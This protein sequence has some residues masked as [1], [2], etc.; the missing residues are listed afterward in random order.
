MSFYKNA[1]ALAGSITR[2]PI[3]RQCNRL[4]DAAGMDR[5]S[6]KCA[7]YTRYAPEVVN[8]S[9]RG[10]EAPA[11]RMH[12]DGGNDNVAFQ[13]WRLGFTG[14]EAPVSRIYLALAG[15]ARAVFGAGANSGLY[16]LAA[17]SASPET[18][19]YAFEP[20]PEAAEAL[21]K[22]VALNN[23]ADRIQVIEKAVADIPGEMDLYIPAKT[24]G[25]ILEQS[26]S[27]NP[28]FRSDHSAVLSVPV[29][30]LDEFRKSPGVPE[31]DLIRIDVES[32]EHRVLLGARHILEE[33]R[34]F[35]ILEVLEAADT[36]AID[37]IRNT[38][39]YKVFTA[40]AGEVREQPRVVYNADRENQILCPADRIEDFR[41]RLENDGFRVITAG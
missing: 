6:R 30:T 27:L 10:G 38:C 40:E 31:P 34:P 22:N 3:G 25:D 32:A 26:A 12:S 9:I 39:G 29:I 23:L 41:N 11:F 1:R 5:L 20:F 2:S 4:V 17:A 21:R 7:R 13:A 33:K 15:E 8:I 36:G 19:L 14:Y 18:R 16:E 28:A 37:E 24:H 35:I